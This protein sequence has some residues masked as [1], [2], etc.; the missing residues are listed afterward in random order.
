MVAFV[1][2]APMD[3]ASRHRFDLPAPYRDRLPEIILPANAA[4]KTF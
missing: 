1:I 4:H 2:R 3:E